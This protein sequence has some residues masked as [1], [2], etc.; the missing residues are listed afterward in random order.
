MRSRNRCL[1]LRALVEVDPGPIA[2]QPEVSRHVVS[3]SETVASMMLGGLILGRLA[4]SASRLV[5]LC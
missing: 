4:G 3:F 5:H 1:H 2:R